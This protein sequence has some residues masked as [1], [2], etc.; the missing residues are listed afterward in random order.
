M[1]WLFGDEINSDICTKVG[2]SIQ[3]NESDL[4]ENDTSATR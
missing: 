2:D 4:A 3:E 1:D